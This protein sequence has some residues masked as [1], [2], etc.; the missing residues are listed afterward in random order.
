MWSNF[1]DVLWTIFWAFAFIAYLFALFSVVADLF[2]DR[3]LNGFWKAV[4]IVFLIF[5]PFLTVLIYLIVRGRGMADRQTERVHHDRHR[6]DD[7]IRS[8]AASPAD[9]IAKAKQLLDS[10]VI[11]QAEF[12]QLKGRALR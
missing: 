1:W 11:T 7:Y 3:G 10:G 4:W 5:L 2:R 9:E 12:D 6:A 8:V